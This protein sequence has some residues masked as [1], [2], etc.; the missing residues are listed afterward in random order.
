M[1]L[2]PTRKTPGGHSGRELTGM[3]V[4]EGVPDR[5]VRGAE[6]PALGPRSGKNGDSRVLEAI[7]YIRLMPASVDPTT[8]KNSDFGRAKKNLVSRSAAVRKPSS[9]ERFRPQLQLLH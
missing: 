2:T 1:L 3:Y 5:G 8:F 9:S 6:P 7:F 4:Q